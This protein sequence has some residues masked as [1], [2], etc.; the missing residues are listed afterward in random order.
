MVR[1]YTEPTQVEELTVALSANTRRG[2][3]CF[4]GASDLAYLSG[5]VYLA[6]PISVDRAPLVQALALLPDLQE[7]QLPE[8]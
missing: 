8:R 1:L 7:K 2:I 5:K 4:K 6:S 3:K